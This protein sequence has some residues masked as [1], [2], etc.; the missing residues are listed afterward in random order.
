MLSAP[1][2]GPDARTTVQIECA[3]FYCDYNNSAAVPTL[4]I[5]ERRKTLRPKNRTVQTNNRNRVDTEYGEIDG[6]HVHVDFD[7]RT[8]PE[9]IK[10][11]D[12]VANMKNIKFYVIRHIYAYNV[13]LKNK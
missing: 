4:W 3:A 13:S 1:A 8:I 11:Q 9:L 5:V 2:I 7:C 12:I 10:T 6:K